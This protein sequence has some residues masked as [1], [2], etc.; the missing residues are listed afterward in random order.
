M[1]KFIKMLSFACVIF[2]ATEANAARTFPSPPPPAPP[3]PT[4]E[5]SRMQVEPDEIR[6][7]PVRGVHS[8]STDLL[9]NACRAKIS[10]PVSMSVEWS[11]RDKRT[12]WWC[13]YK[14]K[15]AH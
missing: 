6:F 14:L 12:G 2:I 4:A 3:P 11:T 7:A 5:G 9:L 8:K 10:K 13:K 1:T 15:S